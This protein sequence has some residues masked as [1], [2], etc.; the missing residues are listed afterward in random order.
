MWD[1]GMNCWLVTSYDVCKIIESDEGTY[2]ILVAD[3][4][5]WMIEIRGG[6]AGLSMQ[7]GDGHVRM[8]R[9]Y[10][11]LFN[12]P[13]MAKYRDL[14]VRPVVD[15]TIDG[16]ASCGNAELFAQLADLV[17]IRVIASLCGLPWRDEAFINRMLGTVK[18]II[19]WI[20]LGSPDDP[21]LTQRAKVAADDFRDLVR[22]YVL[23]AKDGSEDNFI[24]WIWANAA[25]DYGDV[26]LEDMLAITGDLIGAAGHTTVHGLANVMYVYLS[27]K[28]VRSAVQADQESALNALIEEALRTLGS[29]Q[30]RFRK[31]NRD[32]AVGGVNIKKDD[33]ICLLHAAA[34]RDPEHYACP[35][36]VDLK[37]KRVNDHLAFNVG[38]RTCVGMP[39]ARLEIRECL[40]A[41]I[42]R[43]PEL[44]LD[45]SK[46]PPRFMGFSHRSYSPL[47]VTF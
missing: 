43:F 6:K 39:L 28:A 34:N 14:H 19:A 33:V 8:R 18:P 41:L 42:T 9:L 45:T 38:P 15:H 3:L 25:K 5:D 47:H 24:S 35:H 12:A 44:R 13:V 21:E 10:M 16:F 30:W 17:P 32:V 31:S 36:M 2:R 46:E 1:P 27:D 4:P 40:K 23:R 22:P 29:P 11:K 26:T 7:T 20:G 37:R